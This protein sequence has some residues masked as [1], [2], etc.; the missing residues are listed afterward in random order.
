M[1]VKARYYILNY[2]D[3]KDGEIL[4]GDI[5]ARGMWIS[6]NKKYKKSLQTTGR[7][8]MVDLM[9][10]KK[11]PDKSIEATYTEIYTLSKDVARLQPDMKAIFLPARRFQTLLKS[12]PEEYDVVRDII[13]NQIDTTNKHQDMDIFLLKLQEKEAQL[14]AKDNE[15]AMAAKD[16]DR[17]KEIYRSP[18]RR[19]SASSGDS[20][21]H[22][23]RSWHRNDKSKPDK[24]KSKESGCFL[25]DGP[26]RIKDCTLLRQL[27]KL[28]KSLVEKG[29]RKNSKLVKYKGKVYNADDSSTVSS[30]ESIDIDSNNEEHM[31][32]IAALSKE[33]VSTIPRSS[34][35][36]DTGAT[37]HMTDQL[38]LFSEPLKSIKRRTIKVGGGRLYS[39]QCGTITMKV[40]NG[41]C[42][43]TEVLYVP[44]LGVNL[45]S[46]K[47]FT[48]CGLRGSFDNDGLYIH[49]KKGIEVLRAPA[50]G[51]VYIV[52]KLASELDKFVLIAMD[53]KLASLVPIILPT[54]SDP[55][56]PIL[57]S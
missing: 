54:I 55:R 32:E 10:Y 27:R 16:K 48:R 5:R 26:H 43:L 35:I 28:A 41:E 20:N 15:V 39:V 31:E 23:S 9:N 30:A 2:I 21:R 22:Q 46:G 33:L 7:Q 8:L 34:W 42:R 45:L 40:Q 36:A 19:G 57:E 49:T 11:S 3:D 56:E 44:N 37:S 38:R 24:P 52:D 29:E 50:R 25:C 51:G 47:R 17:K 14:Q 13:D 18:H 6:L 4:T 12:L 53:N 1:D